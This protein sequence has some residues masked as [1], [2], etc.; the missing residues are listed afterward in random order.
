MG[1]VV[2]NLKL[3]MNKIIYTVIFGPYEELKEPLVITPDWRYICFTDQPFMSTTW[4]VRRIDAWP[5][6]RMHSREYKI[7]FDRYI[8]AY[9]SIYIDGSFQINCDLNQWWAKHFKPD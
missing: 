6:K 1:T 8:D 4:E 2:N 3:Q 9:Q 5:D 7:N